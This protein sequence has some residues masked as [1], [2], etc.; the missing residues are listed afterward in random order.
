MIDGGL[1]PHLTII[2][3]RDKLNKGLR[4]KSKPGSLRGFWSCALLSPDLPR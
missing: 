2:A 1:V 4:T 3:L